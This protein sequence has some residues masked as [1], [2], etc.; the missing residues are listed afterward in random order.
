MGSTPPLVAAVAAPYVLAAAPT[1]RTRTR[2]NKANFFFG[3]EIVK[4]M[5]LESSKRDSGA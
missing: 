4:V 5:S 3:E 2:A 1:T